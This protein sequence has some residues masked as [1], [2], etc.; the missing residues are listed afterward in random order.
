MTGK[1]KLYYVGPL[2][3]EYHVAYQFTDKPNLDFIILKVRDTLRDIGRDGF[4]GAVFEEIV[5]DKYDITHNLTD[6]L[7]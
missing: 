6:K 4:I 7:K 2:G 1:A 5:N 3:T